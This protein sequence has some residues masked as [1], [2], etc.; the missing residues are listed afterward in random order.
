MRRILKL[1]NWEWARRVRGRLHELI[2]CPFSA[3]IYGSYEVNHSVLALKTDPL[4]AHVDAPS[5]RQGNN[6]QIN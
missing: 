3:P 6:V 4:K 5:P 2:K 1:Q